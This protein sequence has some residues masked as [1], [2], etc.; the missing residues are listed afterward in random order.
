MRYAWGV[1]MPSYKRQ[2]KFGVV[3]MKRR[4]FYRVYLWVDEHPYLIERT[5]RTFKKARSAARH[6]GPGA[7]IERRWW[8][9]KGR[10]TM[11]WV[12]TG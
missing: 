1:K 3:R 10:R 12:Y 6:L 4:V 5:A 7:V 2:T 9:P 8:T 11:E